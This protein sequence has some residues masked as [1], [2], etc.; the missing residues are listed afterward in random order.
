MR[1]STQFVIFFSVFSAVMMGLNWY[2]FSTLF[3]FFSIEKDARYYSAIIFTVFAF[4]LATIME[5]RF[6]SQP[7]RWLYVVS[8]LWI[9]IIFLS[10]SMFLL[11][12]VLTLITPLPDLTGGLLVTNL[13]LLLIAYSI[14]NA[15]RIRIKHISI[16]L[17]KLKKDMRIVHISDIHMGTVRNGA[18]LEKI[19]RKIKPLQPDAVMLTGDLVDGS[20]PLKPHMFDALEELEQMKIPVFYVTGNHEYYEGIDA[21]YDLLDHTHLHVLKDEAVE[22]KGVQVIGV[23]YAM[24][25]D[26]LKNTLA[27]VKLDPKKPSI[28]LYHMPTEISV[29][30]EKGISLML[31]GHTHKGQIF[32][33][34]ILTKIAFPYLYGL[35][36]YKGM[37]LHVSQGTGTWGPYMRLGSKNEIT[38]IELKKNL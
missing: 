33:F 10:C 15:S 18:F 14:I 38:V 29:A 16:E 26:Y 31:S 5:K 12:D 22:F 32:P 13:L 37:R 21:I 8:S 19:V 24:E 20:A 25:R 34:T 30:Q 2:A 7:S 27:K 1:R 35:Y 11:Y 3:T 23:Q 9:G 6:P 28:L 4:P 17:P 36:T